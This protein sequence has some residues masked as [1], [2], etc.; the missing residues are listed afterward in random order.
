MT[1]LSLLGR[2]VRVRPTSM[3]ARRSIKYD[4]ISLVQSHILNVLRSGSLTDEEI[5]RAYAREF[6]YDPVSP[7]GLRTR[8][9][10]L[11]AAGKVKPDG[12]GKTATG[13]TCLRWSRT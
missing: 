12:H 11:V 1:Q 6:W 3:A 7:S 4:E 9:A 8:R 2:S 10:E 5:A 13:R